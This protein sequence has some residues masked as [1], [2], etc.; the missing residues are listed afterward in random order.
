MMGIAVPGEVDRIGPGGVVP[1]D[2]IGGSEMRVAGAV[3]EFIARIVDF[4]KKFHAPGETQKPTGITVQTFCSTVFELIDNFLTVT[5][6]E[7]STLTQLQRAIGDFPKQGSKAPWKLYQNYL[8]D[9]LSLR[10]GKL[11]DGALKFR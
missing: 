8:L 11:D 6:L 5:Y 9:L 2:G 7:T 1:Y 4:T 3:S 10:F